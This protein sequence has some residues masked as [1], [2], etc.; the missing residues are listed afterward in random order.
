MK[1]LARILWGVSIVAA[2]QLCAFAQNSNSICPRFPVG[3]T[4]T[5]PPNL[6]SKNGV[7]KVNFKYLTTV[8]ENGNT[9]FCFITPNGQQSPTLHV[10]PGDHLILTLT[11]MVPSNAAGLPAM[12]M[13]HSSMVPEMQVSAGAGPAVTVCGSPN[14]TSA[15]VNV[16]YH[17][18]NVSPNCHSDEVIHTII[19]SGE[20]FTYNLAFPTDEPPGLY[21]YHPHIHG[22]AEAAVQGGASGAIVVE[23]IENVQPAVAGLPQRILLVRDQ[24]PVNTGSGVPA[25]DLSLNYIPVPFPD[26]TPAIIPM[27]PNERQLWRVGNVSADT[28]I[29]VQ[30]Q[31]DGV[32]QTIQIVGLD[33]VPTGSQDG[34]RRGKLVPAKHV[35]LAP[36]ARAEFIVNGPGPGVKNATL[37]TLGVDTGPVG[38][39]DPTRPLAT[40]QTSF[41]APEPPLSIPAVSGQAGKQRFE[42]LASA[43]VTAKRTLYFSEVL[44]DPTNPLS[45]TNFYITVDGATPTLFDPTLPPAIVTTQGSVEDWTIEN[46]AQENH[47]FHFHQI[48]FQLLAQNG[49]P[50]PPQQ[51]Q[52]LDMINLPYWD[53]VSAYPSVT[54]RMDF[55]GPDIGDFVYHCHILG[56]EDN[57]MMAIIR[58]LPA[59][60]ASKTTDA[61]KAIAGNQPASATPAPKVLD[62]AKAAVVPTNSKPV[63]SKTSD[64][65][66]IDLTQ[67]DEPT[68]NPAGT[69]EEAWAVVNGGA[70]RPTNAFAP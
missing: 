42:G 2:M 10:H 49:K 4:I 33:G 24:L 23:G 58:V 65:K 61:K 9:L 45:P 11:N 70:M 66:T 7:L 51:Q 18:A 47:E 19:N 53:G 28:I 39:N 15:S 6:F 41:S 60:A 48:H 1:N 52:F 54:V 22:I 36:A 64:S 35:L 20:T 40:I 63:D 32:P 44:S 57:G 16:H 34:T 37:M 21:W 56:H 3:S 43:P 5:E 38:D 25:W 27:K 59:S 17:G 67:A 31:Y 29:D 8:D 62:S 14:M 68:L 50:V 46:R 30:L 26:Y 12:H 55:R 69:L 13:N